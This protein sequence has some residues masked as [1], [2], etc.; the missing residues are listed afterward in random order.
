MTH[1]EDTA[2]KSSAILVLLTMTLLSVFPLD[3][4]LPSF[5]VLAKHFR[6]TTAD[7]SLSI[8]LFAVGI[9]LSQL[10]IG[11]CP[12]LSAEKGYY[13]RVWRYRLSVQLGA[14]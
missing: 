3:V 7:I 12:M 2:K 1:S 8:S 10:L 5:P 14:S 6:T 11:P 9:S 4:L 13:W